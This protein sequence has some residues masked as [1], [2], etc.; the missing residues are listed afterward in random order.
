MNEELYASPTASSV[1][2]ATDIC[3]PDEVLRI[4]LR[5]GHVIEVPQHNYR[6]APAGPIYC[7]HCTAAARRDA[8]LGLI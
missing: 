7:E 2:E 1:V 5:C 3:F 8:Y 6:K 4:K